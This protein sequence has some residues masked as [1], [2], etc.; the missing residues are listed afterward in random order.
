MPT[1]YPSALPVDHILPRRENYILPRRETVDCLLQD[2]KF[3]ILRPE[4]TLLADMGS[5]FYNP[6]FVI[7]SHNL[8]TCEPS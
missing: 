1:S 3:S 4:L 8:S 2:L 6:L 5:I 7:Y